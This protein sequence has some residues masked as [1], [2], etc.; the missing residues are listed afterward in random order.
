MRKKVPLQPLIDELL[1]LPDPRVE[2]TKKHLLVDIIILTVCAVL[3]GVEDW[4]SVERYGRAKRKFLGRFLALPNG[5]PS[6]DTIGRVFSLLDSSALSQCFANWIKAAAE[7]TG[8]EVVSVDGKTLRRSFDTA[9]SRSPIHMVNAWA[10]RAMVSLGQLPSSGKG[11]EIETIPDLL[12]MLD[13][14]DC[15][16]TLDAMGCQRKVAEK[17]VQRGGD[18]VLALKGNQG[19]LHAEVVEY[20]EDALSHGFS[21]EHDYHESVDGGHGRVE[22]RRTWVSGDIGWFGDREKWCALRSIVLV[23]S[24][25]DAGQKCTTTRRYY[26]SS[27]PGGDAKRLAAAVRSHWGVENSLHWTLDVSFN[28]DQCRVRAG[29]AAANFAVVRQIAHN[30]LKSETTYK[31]GVKAK[32]LKCGWRDDYL[33]KVLLG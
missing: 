15:T 31:A 26:V 14:E 3:S 18:Y 10:S 11:N 27:L 7:L 25:R 17:I 30:L 13:I 33:M 8:G 9:S 23:E 12:D 1:E 32:R 4:V 20:F 21:G 5:I 19:M 2:R 16:V 29:H 6:H 22:T 24:D 28:E